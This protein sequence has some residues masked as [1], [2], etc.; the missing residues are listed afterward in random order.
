M[1]FRNYSLNRSAV[2]AL[3]LLAACG[4]F[5]VAPDAFK[6]T[7]DQNDPFSYSRV[8]QADPESADFK[9]EALDIYSVKIEFPLRLNQNIRIQ[10]IDKSTDEATTIEQPEIIEEE[11][12][13]SF[14]DTIN[15]KG[16]KKSV[17]DIEYIVYSGE[18]EIS[19]KRLSIKPTL[20]VSGTRTIDKLGLDAGEYDFERIYFAEGARLVTN[21]KSIT[22]NVEKLVANSGIIETFTADEAA[23]AAPIETRGRSGG[24]IKI[25]AQ[26]A[27][28]RLS[29]VLRGTK[30]GQGDRGVDATAEGPKGPDSVNATFVNL[31][32]PSN[33]VCIQ[34]GTPA[35]RGG[36]GPKGGT[37]RPGSPGGSTGYLDLR[38]AKPADPEH[39]IS[40]NVERLPGQGGDP[41]EGGKGGPGGPG[42]NA[43]GTN[44][45]HQPYPAGE[46]GPEGP[47]GDLGPT[48][49]VGSVDKSCVV[50]AP[51]TFCQ[52]LETN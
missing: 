5:K 3:L 41:G 47:R 35:G 16:A 43:V 51:A 38:V 2:S 37:S 28:G 50:V 49:A 31:I 21:G 42:G 17:R 44:C 36:E 20:Y 52:G 25:S 14:T 39:A 23:K 22:L 13:A 7:K 30:G 27:T 10:R 29:V 6:P 8:A 18:T 46:R 19:R 45:A 48:G 26:E 11:A 40:V 4:D 24:A 9:E 12:T 34:D 1:S 32:F 15:L 33:R